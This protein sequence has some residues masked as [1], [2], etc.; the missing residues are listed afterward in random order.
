MLRGLGEAGDRQ[1]NHPCPGV[2]GT[3]GVGT[4]GLGQ[5]DLPPSD[6]GVWHCQSS[7][8]EA[9]SWHGWCQAP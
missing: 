3:G 8:Q 7:Q 9:Q 6:L 4:W 1:D 2:V 5:E